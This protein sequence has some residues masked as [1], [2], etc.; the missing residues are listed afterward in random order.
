MKNYNKWN[1]FLQQ[2]MDR[3]DW[4]REFMA[5]DPNFK[6][7]KLYKD[8]Y[9]TFNGQF[10]N[11]REGASERLDELI[12]FYKD[13]DL[14]IFRE[15]AA[16]LSKYH[17]SIVNSFRYVTASESGRYANK[18]RR[19]S[20]G[21]MESFNNIPSGYRTQSHGIDDFEFTRNRILWS[22]RKDAPILAVPKSA[23]EVHNYT[24]KK[25]GAYKKGK[26]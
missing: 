14:Q 6:K 13:C 21:P 16:L 17:D 1:H 23:A 2:Y 11:N 9:E 12:A 24:G 26:H 18:L 15:F 3:Y 20:N 4:E 7:I 10:V 25:R 5:L 19:L 22:H 8:L